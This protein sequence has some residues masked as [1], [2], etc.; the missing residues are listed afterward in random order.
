MSTAASFAKLGYLMIKKETTA[1]TAVYPDQPIEILSSKIEV[2]WDHTSVNPIAQT[3]SVN[4]RTVLN[5]VGAFNGTIEMY[6]E[7]NNIGNFLNGLFGEDTVTTLAAGV[8]LQHDWEPLNTVPTYTF[9]VKLANKSYVERFFGVRVTKAVFAIDENKLKATIDFSAQRV[10]TNARV[11]TAASSGTALVVDQTSGLVAGSDTVS[12]LSSSNPDT[13][14]ADLTVTTVTN[15]TTLVVSTIGAS[16]AVNDIVVIKSQTPDTEAYDMADELTWAGGA[17]VYINSGANALQNLSAKTNCETMELTFESMTEPRW[18]ATGTDVVDRMPSTILLKGFAVTGK[19]SQFFANPQFMDYLRSN[20]QL[21]LR[22]NFW[23][24]TLQA[25]SAA[26][27]TGTIESSGAG[28]VTV[29]VDTAGEAG[30][31]YAILIVQGTTTLSASITNKLIT[32]TLDADAADNAVALVATAID[33]LSGVAA[34]SA[35]TGNVTTTD[36]PDKIFFASGRDA[37]EKAL[38]RFD[39]P[40]ARIEPF[41]P[42]LTGDDTVNEEIT[43]TGVWD[44]NDERECLVR[45]RNDEASY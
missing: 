30:N 41:N 17:D 15:E 26:A 37:S 34:V 13:N 45:L 18:A 23:G 28:T 2:N 1:G 42:D 22:F 40:N 11:T 4:F 29:T 25:N 5:R 7:V 20:T 8:S 31:D 24:A 10:F 16:L 32:V 21:G 44:S 35:S 19:F 9:D 12:V 36:N 27:A 38:L 3:R 6:T 43:F 39:F 33:N 14:L